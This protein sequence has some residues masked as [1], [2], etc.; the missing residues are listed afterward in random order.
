MNIEI[1]NTFT[2][3]RGG[4]LLP[5]DFKR[6]P[7]TPKRVFI[8]R[9][10]PKNTVRGNH[11]QFK[12]QQ[13]LICVKG[14]IQVNVDYGNKKETSLIK[15]GEFIHVPQMVW[16][17]QKFLT[18]SDIMISI[19]STIYDEKDYILNKKEFLKLIK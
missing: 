10:V 12:T 16:D 14:K 11:A 7:F 18:G 5:I 17:S 9:D 8:V 6:L 13:F 15:E 3:E 4:Y 1:Y 19:C 2:D